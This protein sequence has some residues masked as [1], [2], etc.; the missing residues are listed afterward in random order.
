[1][2]TQF[3]PKLSAIQLNSITGNVQANIEK[4]EDLEK[5]E[6]LK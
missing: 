6:A 3:R 2:E 5:L 4:V 1:M